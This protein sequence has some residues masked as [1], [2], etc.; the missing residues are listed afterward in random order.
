MNL[1]PQPEYISTEV[2][3]D[4]RILD[5]NL[6]LMGLDEKWLE[7]Q[8]KEQGFKNAKEIFLG[9]CDQNKQ[10]SLYKAE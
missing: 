1:S 8:I 7:K 9:I 4:G 10:L 3:M 5:D 6:K 2:I